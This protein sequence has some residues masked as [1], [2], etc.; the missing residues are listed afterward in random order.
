MKT[1]TE[2]IKQKETTIYMY[3]FTEIKVF[4]YNPT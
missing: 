2:Y 3:I 4:I 1:R